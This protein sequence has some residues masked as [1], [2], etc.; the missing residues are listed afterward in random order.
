MSALIPISP[1]QI[2]SWHGLCPRRWWYDRNRPRTEHPAAAY[3]TAVHDILEQYQRWGTAPNMLHPDELKAR[4]AKTAVAGLGL[5]SP[6]MHAV[7]E[8]KFAFAFDRVRYNGRIDWWESYVQHEHV[9]IGDHKTIGDLARRKT[10][11]ELL[12]DAQR[13]IYSMWAVLRFGVKTVT[14]RW[15]YY[16]RVTKAKKAGKAEA[17]QF[18]EGAEQ[19]RERFADLHQKRSLPILDAKLRDLQGHQLPRNLKSCHLFPPHGCPHADECLR[20]VSPLDRAAASICA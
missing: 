16:R 3:G 1:S 15:V 11:A 14:A 10:E 17:V 20:D 5:L 8:E 19:I 7:A 13:I 2:A 12:D 4:H 9:L 18:T 6:P